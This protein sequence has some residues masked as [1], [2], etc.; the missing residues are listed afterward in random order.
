[1]RIVPRGND[2]HAFV[3]GHSREFKNDRRGFSA[4]LRWA[5]DV[6]SALLFTM[7]LIIALSAAEAV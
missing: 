2:I 1:M 4:A 3:C 5:A 7:F 6:V